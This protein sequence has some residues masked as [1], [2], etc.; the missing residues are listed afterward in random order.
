M[1]PKK[2]RVAEETAVEELTPAEVVSSSST[3]KA[4]KDKKSIYIEHCKSWGAFKT[5]A[6][7][8]EKAFIDMGFN[9]SINAT[10]PRKGVR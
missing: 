7:K 3:L 4:K 6:L 9:V 1:P 8:L 10:K 5:R 2:K